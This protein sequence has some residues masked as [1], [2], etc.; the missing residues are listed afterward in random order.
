MSAT[1]RGSPKGRLHG[2]IGSHLS[3]FYGYSHIIVAV[4]IELTS[5]DEGSS[6]SSSHPR[7]FRLGWRRPHRE[8]S[9]GLAG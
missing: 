1:D 4:Q 3:V 9:A 6:K 8:P 2:R 5:I 7:A